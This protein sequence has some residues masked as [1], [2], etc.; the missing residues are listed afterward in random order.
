MTTKVKFTNTHDRMAIVATFSNGDR[1]KMSLTRGGERMSV[2]QLPTNTP[3]TKAQF[4]NIAALVKHQPKELNQVRFDR[5]VAICNKAV[6][7]SDMK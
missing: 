7:L 3:L 5:I 2:E 1:F 4:E 6:T